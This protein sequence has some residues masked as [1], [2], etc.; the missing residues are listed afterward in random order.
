MEHVF[1]EQTFKLL[2]DRVR[3]ALKKT[4]QAED[5]RNDLEAI[6]DMVGVNWIQLPQR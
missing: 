4:T 6:A 1:D 2:Q 5:V 3:E